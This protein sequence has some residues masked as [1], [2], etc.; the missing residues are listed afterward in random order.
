MKRALSFIL[1][2]IMCF[3]VFG[4]TA[5]QVAAARTADKT[6]SARES[7]SVKD[8]KVTYTV[9]ISGGI[10]G[11]GGAVVLVKYDSAV[12]SPVEFLPAYTDT[13]VQQFNGEYVH[14][15]S[16]EY[17]DGYYA[18][19]YTNTVPEKTT[20]NTEFFKLTFEVIGEE[21]PVTNVEFLCKEFFSTTDS[22]DS[23]TVENGL[24]KIAAI[25]TVTL[26]KPKLEGAVLLTNAILFSW[27][28]TAG[29][30]EYEIR[31]K[32][33]TG[34]W[35]TLATVSADTL[36]YRDV[37]VESGETYIYSVRAKNSGSQS[38]FD[39]N[40]VSCK[41][42]SK[43]SN[44][45]AVN[46]VGGIDIT[47]DAT[48]GADSY[49]IMRRELGDTEWS[50][51]SERSATLSPSYKDTT[52]ENGKT[53]EYD[54][55][56]TLGNFTTDTLEEGKP[57]T[58]LPSP[59]VVSV[60][61]ISD[62]I[63]LKW[64]PVENAVYYAVYRRIVG[65]ETELTEYEIVPSTSFVDYDVVSGKTYTYSVKAVND[66]G[67][68]AFTKTGYTLTRVPSTTVTGLTA[69]ADNIQV[70]WKAVSDVDGYNIYRKTVD[71]I[72]EKAGT[73]SK[74]QTTYN[75][76]GAG[77]GKTYYY[78][79]VPFIG[80]SES[81]KICSDMSVYYLKSPQNV[82]A[83]N[84]KDA[85]KVSWTPSAGSEEY[86]VFRQD[87]LSEESRL[88]GSVD[89]DE[90]EYNDK[91]IE[92]GGLY[93]YYVQAVS[94]TG[95]SKYSD[96]T[97]TV[98]RILC[99]ENITTKIL[100]DGV[101]VNWN[102]HS[103]AD[104]YIVCRK[105]GST[106]TKL[107]ATESTGYTDNSVV[108]GQVYAYSVIPVVDSYEGGI[109][110]TAVKT[111]KYLSAPKISSAKNSADSIVVSWSKVDGAKTYEL[112][113][114]SA[115]SNGERTTSYKTIAT[116]NA[117]KTQYEDKGIKDGQGYIY[118]V[119][120]VD[121]SDKSVVSGTYNAV[122]LG[123][124]Y[125]KSLSNA[126]GGVKITWDKANGAK[127]YRLYRKESGGEWVYITK[128]SSSATSYT[129]KGAK[130]GVKT[131]YAVRSE[132]GNSLSTYSSKSFTY[133]ASPEVKVS[134][135]TSA[136][137]VSWSKIS[138][139]TSYYV[140]RK[141]SGDTSWK[142]LGIVT[143]NIYTDKDV[144]DGKTY[145]YTVKAYNGKTFSG[146][147]TSGWSIK[148][149][150]APKLKSIVN[151]TN[152]I[153]VKWDKS[154]GASEYIVYRKTGSA[155]TWEKIY[156]TK[157][158]SY[159]DKKV[160]AGKTYIYTVVAVSGSSRST[161]IA[162]GL[163]MKRLEIPSLKNAK[164]SKSGVTINWGEVTGA[165]GYYIYRKDSASGS[166][167]QIAK[168]SGKTTTSYLDKTAQKGKTY[169]YTVRAYSGSYMSYYN[170]DGLKIKDKY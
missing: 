3:S 119:Y 35:N 134:N 27:R 29:A 150:S 10:E 30:T 139:A 37:N 44:I 167:K 123:T 106:W 165:S 78:C 144:K 95:N 55:N 160:S 65:V 56:S 169:Y 32:T 116:V 97:P 14:G 38:T 140:Y 108:S 81:E 112:Q 34:A 86:L 67:E 76:K 17:G 100:S 49:K 62:G 87:V 120:A 155:S 162:D 53:Y 158:L 82:T 60:S 102:E 68:S 15:I 117:D 39:A 142:R 94:T 12:L 154:T 149:L 74:T 24:Q 26:E 13:G 9:S 42:I 11:F 118:R 2:I 133:F 141:A 20:S 46:G 85:I 114:A 52:V 7:E 113:R 36:Y 83:V 125:I 130:N 28:E 89:A 111:V 43:P 25:E 54:V 84:T 80:S 115:D 5:V 127:Y 1:C 156:T 92:I 73:A 18:V 88:I 90:T 121:G 45:T 51:I 98:K 31:R 122:F 50:V 105:N 99:V 57:V 107:Y 75:D 59:E 40:G 135:K 91:N 23:I 124:K 153:T 77:S 58:Y 64:N 148:R 145:I 126:Y 103:S 22:E 66:Y 131:Y 138:G 104:Y 16:A 47:W 137:T 109:D 8:G 168:V 164:S 69:L 21:R 41:Y 19:G 157:S 4:S 79:A 101:S 163:K 136:I 128:V 33:P 159:T 147:N 170:K 61:N 110:E 6:F 151:S 72:W 161:Y 93:S 71:G 143:K 129:D 48:K 63:E 96:T 132:N 70:T 152:G 146:Y 166:W